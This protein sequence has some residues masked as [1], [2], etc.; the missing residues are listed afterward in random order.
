MSESTVQDDRALGTCCSS[1]A[2]VHSG[3]GLSLRVLLILAQCVLRGLILTPHK[4]VYSTMEPHVSSE[5]HIGHRPQARAGHRDEQAI[6][7]PG[8]NLEE[9]T[10]I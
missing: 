1:G 4:G 10:D 9:Q 3:L 7:G 5:A 2:S 6:P 8:P